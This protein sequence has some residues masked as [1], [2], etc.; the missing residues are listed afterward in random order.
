MQIYMKNP[1]KKII[2]NKTA[3]I[4]SGIFPGIGQIY[5]RE[6]MKGLDLIIIQGIFIFFL[7][8]PAKILFPLGVVL[9]PTLWVL[10]MADA[11]ISFPRKRSRRGYSQ[12]RRRTILLVGAIWLFAVII[13]ALIAIVVKG[14]L[15][16]SKNAVMTADEEP[17]LKLLTKIEPITNSDD[18]LP[19]SNS[20]NAPSIIP[21]KDTQNPPVANVPPSSEKMKSAARKADFQPEEPA[22]TSSDILSTPK[23][24]PP[25]EAE[26]ELPP[27]I[28]VPRLEGKKPLSYVI[29]IGAF[30]QFSNAERLRRQLSQ[31]GYQPLML[32]AISSRNQKVH[33]V[34]VPGFSTISATKAIAKKMKREIDECRDC[35]IATLDKPT[36]SV[37]WLR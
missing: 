6:Y 12:L 9:V 10:G 17:K 2:I 35:F 18:T 14:Q 24:T 15:N 27:Q 29:T 37:D 16:P 30:S 4:L 5:K 32:F 19:D 21:A 31:K 7:F 36:V 23:N 25:V 28:D 3:L 22:T 13:F 1:R 20:T 26:P 8:Y 33:V 11:S 34:V